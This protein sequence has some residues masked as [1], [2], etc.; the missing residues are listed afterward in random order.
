MTNSWS[1]NSK[2]N[3]SVT[4]IIGKQPFKA[5]GACALR[6]PSINIMVSIK[7][8]FSKYAVEN[9]H[10]LNIAEEK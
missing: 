10:D 8:Y 9:V 4:E 3:L 6:K 5:L 7:L 1:F 2:S